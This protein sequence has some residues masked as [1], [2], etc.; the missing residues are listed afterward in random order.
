MQD[1]PVQGGT[2][3]LPVAKLWAILVVVLSA[4]ILDLLD[5]TLTNIAAPL[6]ARSLGGGQFLIQWLGTSYA[7][8]MGIFLVL[9]G[10]LGDK[11]GQ[12]RLFLVGIAG[13]TASSLACG[14]AQGPVFLIVARFLQG[15][16]GSLL[17]PQGM[18][19]MA[20]SFPREMMAKA[21][22]VFGPVMGVAAVLGPIFAGFL[23]KADLWG[24]GWRAMFLINIVLGSVGFLLALKFLPA[25]EGDRSVV[26]DGLGSGLLGGAM[27]CLLFGLIDGSSRQWDLQALASVAVGAGFAALFAWRQARAA[28]PLLEPSLLRNRGFTSG[29]IL[30]FLF[31]A[32]VNGLCFVISLF[33]QIGLGATPFDASLQMTPLMI[34]IILASAI[35]PALIGKWG[36]RLIATGLAIT[37]SGTLWFGLL[38]GRPGLGPWSLFPAILLVG[39][40]MGLCFGTLFDVV[41]GDIAPDEAGS[42]S[43]SLSAVQQLAGSA[44]SAVVTTVFFDAFRKGGHLVAMRQSLWLVGIAMVACFALTWLLPKKAG[45]LHH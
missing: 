25:D 36:R 8:A 29:L 40:G 1:A 16:F 7:L 34:G 21:F 3:V 32:M 28:H 23:I 14:L 15:G 19:I 12:R 31:F 20:R 33:L 10:R 18:A 38:L 11:F 27:L 6:V 45:E 41:V 37:A 39:F 35:S 17:I 4:D 42:A 22:S 13:F 30:G 9:G 5:G 44:G 2:S 43:G 26:L 24:T